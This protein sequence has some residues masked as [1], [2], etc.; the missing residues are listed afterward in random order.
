MQL[1][2]IILQHWLYEKFAD[3]LL[4]T[5]ELSSMK[6]MQM[7]LSTKIKIFSYHAMWEK[8]GIFNLTLANQH[9]IS[10]YLSN[11]KA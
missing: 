7:Q 5:F 3:L 1:L 11:C 6:T 10:E 2:Y 9:S 4:I 8:W